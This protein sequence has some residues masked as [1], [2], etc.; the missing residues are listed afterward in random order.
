MENMYKDGY[1][2]YPEDIS[3][4]EYYL[5]INGF[6]SNNTTLERGN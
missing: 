5:K 3:G 6:I 2:K 1:M 4:L